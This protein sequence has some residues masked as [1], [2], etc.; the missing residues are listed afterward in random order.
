MQELIEQIV[1]EVKYAD[2]GKYIS[3][4]PTAD[5]YVDAEELTAFLQT[6]LPSGH[7][8]PSQFVN[9]EPEED[10][11]YVCKV[12]RNNIKQYYLISIEDGIKCPDYFTIL[13]HCK[14]P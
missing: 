10:G 9:G 3:C 4:T 6:K 5:I 11:E 1:D 8:F 2:D 14:L 12:T 13:S 7:I